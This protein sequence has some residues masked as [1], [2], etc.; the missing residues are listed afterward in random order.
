MDQESLRQ[1]FEDI[2][3]LI[4]NHQLLEAKQELIN[5]HYAD[6]ADFIDN[7]THEIHRRIVPMILEDF[8]PITII[9]LSYKSKI[10]LIQILG[11]RQF[12]EFID[13]LD[14]ED[15]IEVIDEL[16]HKR[17]EHILGHLPQEKYQQ[18][19]EGFRYPEYSVGRIMEKKF[20]ALSSSWTIGQ[21]IDSIRKSHENIPENF[22][23]AIVVDTKHRPLGNILLS[24][25]LKYPRTTPIKE[26]MNSDLKV[27]DTTTGQDELSYIFKQYALTI[28]PVI[29]KF[30]KL[31]GTVSINN[32][33][34]IIQ[35]QAEEDI[36]HLGG[37]HEVDIYE[38]LLATAKQRFPWL[39]INLI[40]AFLTSLIINNFG[41][42]I[43]KLVAL[44]SIMPI[45]ASMGGNAGTQTMT[46]T[47][48]AIANKDIG[49]KDS[50]RIILKELLSCGVNGVLL[51]IL[52]GSLI[53]V[54]FNDH[55]L[56]AVFGLAVIIN[57]LIAGLFGSAIPLFFHTFNIDP[58]P[59]SGVVLTAL[60]DSCG[61]FIFLGL[62]QFLLM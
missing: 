61:F 51:A 31:V 5:L 49:K 38:N 50:F 9:W 42:T 1:L 13:K 8:N 27:A 15:A 55:E 34:Y 23:A 47:I 3:R 6:L 12:A 21:A 45:V 18:I 41:A 26:V 40:T 2:K 19:L 39:F 32:I 16:D 58:A 14:I 37:L 33:V 20:V 28:V 62:A 24:S 54:L 43:V 48:R 56:S 29:N 57:F 46:V 35:N 25:L 44:A 7:T 52:G 22:H 10:S 59:A 53:L 36:L 30:G 11:E 60:T 17:R 4:E